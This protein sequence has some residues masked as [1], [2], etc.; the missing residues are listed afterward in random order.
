LSELQSSFQ[1]E[2]PDFERVISG[3]RQQLHVQTLREKLRKDCEQLQHTISVLKLQV[4]SQGCAG[5]EDQADASREDGSSLWQRRMVNRFPVEFTEH[6]SRSQRPTYRLLIS[7]C[8]K[9]FS[10]IFA[11]FL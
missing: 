4:P 2:S 10:R 6:V 7:I 3:F 5:D 9:N 8:R 11:Q 1:S